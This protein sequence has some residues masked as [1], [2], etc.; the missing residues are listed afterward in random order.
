[1]SAFVDEWSA[2]AA[3]A[4][5]V[6]FDFGGVISV[7][8]SRS[9]SLYP[10]CEARGLDRAAVDAGWTKYRHLWDGGFITFDEMYRRIFADAG[11]TVS[12][13]DLAALWEVDAA[14]WIR[15]LRPE[16]LDLMRSLKADGRALGILTNMSPD[17][18]ERLF[19]PRAA[20]YRAL[21]DAEVV[22]GLERLYKPQRAIY[23]LMARR[24]A[25]PPESLLFFDDTP[26]NVEAA[27]A[28]GWQAE[29][30]PR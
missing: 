21:V 17:F 16:T 3:H 14:A 12:A 13:D 4:A 8:P 1:M 9:C 22:S 15:D 7:A 25:L 10:F 30:Y 19:V 28:C 20:A 29:V 18:Y 5:G 26:A 27:R 23:G 6:V 24:L 11:R 2:R